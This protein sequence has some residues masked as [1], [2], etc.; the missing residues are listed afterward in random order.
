MEKVGKR[1]R[2]RDSGV[3][4][5]VRERARAQVG[6]ECWLTNRPKCEHSLEQF[7]SGMYS[8]FHHSSGGGSTSE[9]VGVKVGARARVRMEVRACV[10]VGGVR[11]RVGARVEGGVGWKVWESEWE[12][13]RKW[14]WE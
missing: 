12:S 11:G 3:R 8:I 6:V 7:Y 5:E 1:I 14:E 4:V 13:E 10:G 9:G 2:V